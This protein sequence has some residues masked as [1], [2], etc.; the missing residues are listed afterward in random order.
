MSRSEVPVLSDRA[1]VALAESIFGT[2]DSAAIGDMIGAWID[3]HAEGAFDGVIWFEMS[4]GAGAAVRL[5]DGRLRFVKVWPGT[6]D[7]SEL[8]AQ[9]RVQAA[10]SQRGY[11]APGVLAGPLPLGPGVAVLMEFD[12]RGVTTDVRVPGVRN[13]MARALARLVRDAQGF[14]APPDLPVRQLPEAIWP[15]PHYVLF[16]FSATAT[17]A[18]WLDA[19]AKQALAEMRTAR[20]RYVVGH[21]DWSAKNMRMGDDEIA[22]VYDWDAVFV[23]RETFVVGSAAANFP[24]TWELPVP[25]T[26]TLR[27]SAAFLHAY[28]AGRGRPFTEAERV[29]LASGMTYAR[30]Y[31]ARCEHAVDPHRTGWDGS[32]RQA[33]ERWGPCTA[34]Q[35]RE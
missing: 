20:A 29:E 33:L 22:V 17:G 8:A 12:R 32:A 2:A 21:L 10:L 1:D 24:V 35:L 26:P 25:A 31:T 14:A 3:R 11:P 18:E 30:A 28:E 13:A 9:F 27:E 5:T 15:K 4:V 34:D 23:D 6:V 7:R 16:D 19:L